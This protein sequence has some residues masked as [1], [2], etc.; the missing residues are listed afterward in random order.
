[1]PQVSY[2]SPFQAAKDDFDQGEG[3]RDGVVR[4]GREASA[5]DAHGGGEPGFEVLY[6]GPGG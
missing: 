6:V 1:M 2:F 4:P 5:G 3:L